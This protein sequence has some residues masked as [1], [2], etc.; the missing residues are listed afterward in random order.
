MAYSSSSLSEL[1]LFSSLDSFVAFNAIDLFFVPAD[2]VSA[3]HVL[4]IPTDRLVS[5]G[6][7]MILL[8]VILPVG[9]FVSAGNYGLCCWFR[10]HAGRHTSP[11]G[12]IS[13]DRVFVY[14]VNTS[15]YAAELVCAGSI[16]FLLAELFLLVVTCLCCLNLVSAVLSLI[17]LVGWSL[18]LVTQFLLVVSIP[19]GVSMYLLNE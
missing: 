12:F 1:E 5:V 8:G 6:S 19:A 9:C 18:P 4:I 15:F 16:M 2:Y 11:G 7:T 14:A 13:A 3:G 10:V 17:L